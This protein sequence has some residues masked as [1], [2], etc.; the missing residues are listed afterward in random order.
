MRMCL[1]LYLFLAVAYFAFFVPCVGYTLCLFVT[2]DCIAFS[3]GLCD[4]PYGGWCRRFWTYD[5]GYPIGRVS[6]VA[7]RVCYR[8]GTQVACG[9]YCMMIAN[10]MAFLGFLKSIFVDM[11]FVTNALDETI[12]YEM[13]LLLIDLVESVFL[14]NAFCSFINLLVV[15]MRI[16]SVNIS[17]E[18]YSV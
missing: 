7:I 5:R 9:L 14:L 6:L 17:M 2:Y 12:S 11:N 15:F 10:G 4:R 8:W 1:H 18:L 13:E 3:W 16:D